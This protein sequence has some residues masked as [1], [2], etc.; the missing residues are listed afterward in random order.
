M[1][2]KLILVNEEDE[3]IGYCKKMNAHINEYLHRAF[4]LFIYNKTDNKLLI[5]KRALGKYHSGGLWTNSCCSHPRYGENLIDSVIR[6]TK[7]E[8]GLDINSYIDN[9]REVGKFHYYKKFTDCAENEI[10]HV[11]M[12]TIYKQP[13]L[14]VDPDE[15]DDIQWKNINEIV[16]ELEENPDQFTAW[17][18]QAFELFVST[19][20]HGVVYNT[21][22]N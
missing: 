15:I 11:F 13:L 5:H 9:L 17:F 19:L 10:D 2:N 4:S 8:L 18:P 1:D 12:L 7:E 22:V 6:R 14:D 16:Q 3:E 20:K 21:V